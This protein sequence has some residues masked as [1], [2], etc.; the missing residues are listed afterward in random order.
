MRTL[1]PVKPLSELSA[2]SASVVQLPTPTRPISRSSIIPR[3]TRRS[4]PGTA[5]DVWMSQS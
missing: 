4:F 5:S 1:N 3:P 2:F